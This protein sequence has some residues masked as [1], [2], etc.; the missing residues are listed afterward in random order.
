M[1]DT[2]DHDEDDETAAGRGGEKRPASEWAEERKL[3][4]QYIA[5]G[6]G[7]PYAASRVN[8]EYWK[9]AAAKAL[10]GWDDTTAITAAELDAA[11]KDA[12]TGQLIR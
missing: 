3:L 4:P 8:P 6:G 9:W 7:V 10:R 12:T 2:F 5:G 1:P 11:I